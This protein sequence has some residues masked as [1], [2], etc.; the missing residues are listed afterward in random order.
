M[1]VWF[2]LIVGALFGNFLWRGEG[3]ILGGIAGLIVGAVIKARQKERS[4]LSPVRQGG[5]ATSPLTAGATQYGTTTETALARRVVD[6]E[7]KLA[8]LEPRLL[9]L[10][11]ALG[12]DSAAIE[13][14]ALS[15]IPP[16]T[17]PVAERDAESST[18]SDAPR[19]VASSD[20]IASEAPA[21]TLAFQAD[22]T[23]YIERSAHAGG[24]AI[25][26]ESPPPPTEPPPTNPI[27]A[28]ITG[29]NP[30]ARI[31][32]VL[33]FIGVGF[34]LK[35]TIEQVY[36]PISVRL[37]G[38]ALGGVALLVLG[39]RLREARFA[40]AMALQG[41]GVGVL[42]LTVFAALRLYSMVPPVA[43]FLLLLWISAT[44][45]W[46]AVRQDAIVLAALS[47]AGGFLA[48]IL[49]SNN[50]GN[51]VLLFTYY[52]LLNC[53][54]F[55]IA[56]FKAWRSLNLLGFAFTFIVGT[57]WGVTRY[58]PENFATTEPFLVLFFLFYVG[59][60]VLYALRRSVELK[61]YVDSALVFGTPLVAAG[62]QSA[63]VRDIEY[64][65]AWSALAM[66]ALY[67]LLTRLLWARRGEGLR[68]LVE[69]FLALGVLF[70]TL[71]IPLALDARWTSAAWAL[72]GAAAVWAGLRQQ[73]RAV[74]AFGLLLQLLAGVAF[75]AGINPWTS[76]ARPPAFPILNSAFVGG[77]FLS[78]AG[79]YN[80][81][82]YQRR[83][84]EVTDTERALTPLVFAWGTLWWLF[85]GWREIDHWLAADTRVSA[86]VGLL[87]FTSLVFVLL[88]RRLV[89]PIAR[90]PAL[91][92]LPLL[93]GLAVEAMAHRWFAGAHLF[94]NGGWLA[95][96]VAIVAIGWMLRRFDRTDDD[97]EGA[98]VVQ[99]D[100]WH[101][102]LLWLFL[103]L[104]AHEL[105]W[106]GGQVGYADGAWAVVPWGL[107]PALG[108]VAVCAQASATRWPIGAHRRGYL[109]LGSI[110]IVA[111][112]ILW[113]VVAN[114]LVDGN[115][116]PLPYVPVAN[117]LDLTQAVVLVAIATWVLNARRVAPDVLRALP[118]NTIPAAF[119]ALVF[120]SINFI[121][122]RTI[123]FWF[124]V[125]FTLH[126]LW[127]STLVQAALSLL[128]SVFALATMV[129]ANRR[130]IR[131]PWVVGAAL[132]GIV[133]AKL[134]VVDLAQVGTVA[135]IVSFIG[136]GLLALLIGY[137]APVPSPREESA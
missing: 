73:R 68:L 114:L 118:A 94:A 19:P 51:H 20:A 2:G 60:A 7:R 95:W 102:G 123:H 66:S 136:V 92:L 34:L 93:L 40:Y 36:V 5:A 15:T 89:W 31:G 128:W 4:A 17:T 10:E 108:L 117:P 82:L 61:S 100:F 30:M 99:V 38:V 88:E 87:T 112:L 44:S 52:A 96:P 129:Y 1:P 71:A 80:A 135:R 54:I 11:R 131:G 47:V 21:G 101:A 111:V 62:L 12:R 72:E 125:P 55:G 106:T 22:G 39:W 37:A 98:L 14:A 25:P 24:P 56:W 84:A 69:T 67:L 29:G 124:D 58:R 105:A 116:A 103:L 79:L 97:V 8:S 13:A 134:F 23:A 110:P 70:A 32:V 77:V 9:E 115:P 120:Y 35:Y 43:A 45:S 65:M 78:V 63:L 83:R 132:L 48:P 137:L 27:W 130:G 6:L 91:V 64:A 59:I 3:A 28:W 107:V 42:Y 16:A 122:L 85:A 53:G 76:T 90:V 121:V 41:G 26:P 18:M 109:V 50:S 46:L 104:T 119:A 49:T 127:R 74:R 133:V 86:M 33:L 81:W 113:S 75:I 126:G 57:L